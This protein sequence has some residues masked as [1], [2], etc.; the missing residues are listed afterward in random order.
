[1]PKFRAIQANQS[2]QNVPQTQ[3]STN[4]EYR[5]LP[6]YYISITKCLIRQ[7]NT[8]SLFRI[9]IEQST[10]MPK[11]ERNYQILLCWSWWLRLLAWVWQQ[12]DTSWWTTC[13]LL[14][15]KGLF[16]S[17]ME[18]ILVRHFSYNIFKATQGE[19]VEMMNHD[20]SM[21]NDLYEELYRIAE[22][23]EKYCTSITKSYVIREIFKCRYSQIYMIKWLSRYNIIKVYIALS[24]FN[25]NIIEQ[26]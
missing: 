12:A 5:V 9:H 17:S 26:I 25:Y 8:K 15:R 14:W 24:N 18:H 23:I 2:I 3:A 22:A 10:H 1:M 19:G 20:C 21:V 13:R 6:I 7:A 16:W 4:G 11:G